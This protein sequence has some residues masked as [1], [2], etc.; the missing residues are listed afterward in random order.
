M[1]KTA[2]ESITR[3][4]VRRYLD[5]LNAF[6]PAAAL[7]AY[8]P[9]ATIRYPGQPRMGVDRF[10]EVLEEFFKLVARF[11]I[12]PRE[13]LETEHGVAARWTLTVTTK[14][15]QT[16]TCPGIDSWVIGADGT[17]ES[18]DVYYDPAPLQQALQG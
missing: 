14:S 7:S 2:Q 13:V 15:G 9:D 5:G 17:I 10:R 12:V 4:P 8:S 11:D 16:V 3:E 6:D 1:T 18:A